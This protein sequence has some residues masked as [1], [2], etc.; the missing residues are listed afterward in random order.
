MNH[1][2]FIKLDI[3]PHCGKGEQA[4]HIGNLVV[5]DWFNVRGYKRSELPDR[6]QEIVNEVASWS[7]WLKILN[8]I[9]L[10]DKIE[11][12]SG[13]TIS[14]REFINMVNESK[15]VNP[16]RSTL[17]L[18]RDARMPLDPEQEFYDKEGFCVFMRIWE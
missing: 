4:I 5:G 13:K 17:E 10:H 9:G 2:Y 16:R 3:C 15:K 6:F 1:S 11:N 8:F 14:T 18:A 7:D 12:E